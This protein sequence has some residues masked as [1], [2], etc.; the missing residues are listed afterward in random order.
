MTQLANFGTLTW[1]WTTLDE[2]LAGYEPANGLTQ[3]PIGSSMQESSTGDTL[4]VPGAFSNGSGGF[5][6]LWK[7]CL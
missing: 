7:V 4:A 2:S 6:D 3:F 5:P 1:S